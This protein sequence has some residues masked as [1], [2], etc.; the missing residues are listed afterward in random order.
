MD[1]FVDDRDFAL[2]RQDPYTF[3]V[4][5]RILRGP[6]AC[7]RSDHSRLILCHSEAPYPVWIWTPDGLSEAEKAAAWALAA[8]CCPLEAGYRLMMKY[9]LAAYFLAQAGEAGMKAGISKELFAYACPEPLPPQETADGGLHRCTE[10]DEKEAAALLGRFFS[11]IGEHRRP[12]E[13]ILEK[14]REKIAEKALFF[15][16][17]AGGRTVACCGWRHNAGLATVNDVYTLP[18]A[19]RKHYA[20]N[21]VYAVTKLARDDG[22]MPTLYTNANYAAS[23]ACYQKIGYTLRGRL[24]TLGCPV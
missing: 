7:V 11:E 8:E 18:Q 19:R 9:E 21:L 23:N 13:V 20:Q 5:D 24:C 1:R 17:D 6:C 22:W 3:S 2:L 4:L 10:A 12:D 15:W 16:K 14:A